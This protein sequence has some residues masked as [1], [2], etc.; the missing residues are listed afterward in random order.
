MIAVWIAF[1]WLAVGAAVS[2]YVGRMTWASVLLW[3]V[4]W[5]ACYAKRLNEGVERLR[6]RDADE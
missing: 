3:P 2:W 1:G 6:R 5:A 4:V